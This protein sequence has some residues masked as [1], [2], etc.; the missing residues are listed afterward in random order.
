MWLLTIIWHFSFYYYNPSIFH[1]YTIYQFSNGLVL[2]SPL[3][4]SFTKN[5]LLF[6]FLCSIFNRQQVSFLSQKL[7]S[8][9][10][11]SSQL[12]TEELA[13]N[14]EVQDLASNDPLSQN[15]NENNNDL[16][17]FYM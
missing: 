14:K 12:N 3:I 11:V 10:R 4:I 15:S 16:L 17:A 6:T 5:Y 8:Q 2:E 7:L 9:L 1:D 13:L